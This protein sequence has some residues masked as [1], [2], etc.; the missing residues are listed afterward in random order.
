[1]DGCKRI[2]QF[3][4]SIVRDKERIYICQIPFY[5]RH[6]SFQEE[7][8]PEKQEYDNFKNKKTTLYIWKSG[9]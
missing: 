3:Q 4:N 2:V 9:A 8:Y 5:L 7:I 1:M 6:L